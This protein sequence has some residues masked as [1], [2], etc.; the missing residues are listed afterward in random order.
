MDNS[1]LT[2]PLGSLN[3]DAYKLPSGEKRIG[4]ESAAIALGVPLEALPNTSDGSISIS[5]FVALAFHEAKATA[6]VRAIV[7]LAA[8]AEVGLESM[9]V[10]Q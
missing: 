8:F 2:V 9:G 4:S 1:I 10:P 3:L 6:N 7:L 5:D